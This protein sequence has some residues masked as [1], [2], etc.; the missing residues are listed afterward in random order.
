ML[1][2]LVVSAAIFAVAPAFAMDPAAECVD[3]MRA[4]QAAQAIVVREQQ[5][6]DDTN[7]RVVDGS[8]QK[9]IALNNE[10]LRH[11][12]MALDNVKSL[13]ISL[14]FLRDHNCA[15]SWN[16]RLDSRIGSVEATY[17]DLQDERFQVD[18]HLRADPPK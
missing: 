16:D 17:K 8:L 5:W 11:S 13:L 10:L 15:P 4:G 6:F 3:S 12:D 7:K 1:K 18:A 9:S 14:R 2:S